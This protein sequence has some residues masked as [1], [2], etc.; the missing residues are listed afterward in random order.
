MRVANATIL[1]HRPARDL[2]A[3]L[4]ERWEAR[5]A[6]DLVVLYVVGT[7]EDDTEFVETVGPITEANGTL[8]V[9]T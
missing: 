4:G 6:I 5:S 7:L 8:I 1:D 9:N 2:S 3:L